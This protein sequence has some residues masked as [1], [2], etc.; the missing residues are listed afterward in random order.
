MVT[1][2]RK[3]GGKPGVRSGAAPLG[4]KPAFSTL[5]AL[6]LTVVV[7]SSAFKSVTLLKKVMLRVRKGGLPPLRLEWLSMEAGAGR[8]PNPETSTF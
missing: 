2:I 5:E 6:R 8:L 1:Q 3:S 4:W 7:T